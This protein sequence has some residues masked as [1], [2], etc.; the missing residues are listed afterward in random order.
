MKC[1]SFV[2]IDFYSYVLFYKYLQQNVLNESHLDTLTV[3]SI[4]W[5]E[6]PW[7]WDCAIFPNER[8]SS[9]IPV[10]QLHL[11]QL[12]QCAVTLAHLQTTYFAICHVQMGQILWMCDEIISCLTKRALVKVHHW[13]FMLGCL[14]SL[15][16]KKGLCHPFQSEGWS[17]NSRYNFQFKLLKLNSYFSQ[18]LIKSRSC[19]LS[20]HWKHHYS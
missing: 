5:E 10:A 3:C 17:P 7:F 18:I 4:A 2:S 9:S 13:D 8:L 20:I 1:W 19:G 14:T 11:H 16:S 15:M 12:H 6:V